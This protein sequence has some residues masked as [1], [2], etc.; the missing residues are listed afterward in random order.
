M[1][2]LLF[3][4]NPITMHPPP[5]KMF[6]LWQLLT[7]LYPAQMHIAHFNGGGLGCWNAS[8]C[9]RVFPS[10]QSRLAELLKERIKLK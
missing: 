10:S 1:L 8:V 6:L 2:V 3:P 4:H 9:M 5:P 7:P